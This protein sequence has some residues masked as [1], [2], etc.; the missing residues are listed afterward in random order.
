MLPLIG[1]Q[2]KSIYKLLGYKHTQIKSR[3]ATEY[4]EY[5]APTIM[6]Q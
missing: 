3:E 5:S 4:Y 2:S 1:P 6:L